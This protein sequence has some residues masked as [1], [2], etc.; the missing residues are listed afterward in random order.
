M[1]LVSEYVS[2]KGLFM[3]CRVSHQS[4]DGG[5]IAAVGRLATECT[6]R[7]QLILLDGS[8]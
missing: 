3:R 5:E 1:E 2:S 6:M 8:R 7:A 4:E